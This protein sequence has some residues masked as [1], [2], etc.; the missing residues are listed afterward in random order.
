MTTVTAAMVKELRERTGAGMMDCKQA[1]TENGGDMDAAIDWLRKR[2]LSKAAKKSGRIAAQGLIG[3]AVENKRGAMVEVNSE[4]D[5]VAR[6]GQFQDMVRAIADCALAAGGDLAKLLAATYPGKS[7]TVQAYVQEMIATI[8]ENMSV[9]RTAAVD[10]GSGVIAEYV[11]G[12][13]GN[14]VGKIGV[15]V[16]VESNGDHAKVAALARQLALHIAAANPLSITVEELDKQVIAR[17]REI[18]L[19]QAAASGKPREI[20]EK[21]VEGRLRKEFLQQVVLMQ[22]TFLGEG[23]DGKQTVEQVIKAAEKDAGAPI[24]VTKFVRFALGEGI[25]KKDEDFAAEVAAAIKT[26]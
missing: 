14:R 26:S 20:I 16:A 25:E 1:L 3:L 10:V 2:G 6:N 11:H 5:F 18:Y 23:G 12:K 15:L 21:M 8:G 17:E 22:Q 7:V 19:E 13:L 4:T 24:K 9:R